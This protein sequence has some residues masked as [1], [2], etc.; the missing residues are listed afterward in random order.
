MFEKITIGIKTFLRDD[1]LF[2]ALAGIGRYMPTASVVV[3]DD[4]EP[5]LAKTDLYSRLVDRGSAAVI[6]PFDSGFGVKSNE[7][8]THTRTPYLLVG[9][10]DF[11]FDKAAA[12]S[13]EEMQKT[14]DRHPEIDIISG[15]VNNRAYEF[16]WDIDYYGPD[17]RLVRL[18]EVPVR[19]GISPSEFLICD[20][21]ANFSLIRGRVLDTVSWDNDVKI[22]GGEHAAWFFD[23]WKHGFRT[24]Y[25]FGA[26]INE[27]SKRS[28]PR[29]QE[30]RRRAISSERP[31]FKSRGIIE[32][33]LADG[34]VD[35]RS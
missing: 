7:I 27:Q 10:D 31:C 5:S 9:S 24:A 15:R 30:Y 8:A 35:Y 17:P 12:Q 33:I 29:Y 2:E 20:L 32:Y 6:L 4:G 21:T 19:D 25:K 13:I 11:V 14:L 22:G 28:T 26:N 1:F 3:A 34:R 23:C 16:N 18:R